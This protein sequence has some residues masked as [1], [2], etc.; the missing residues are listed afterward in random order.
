MPAQGNST[1]PNADVKSGS[2][3][4]ADIVQ[5]LIDYP[6]R[7]RL[8]ILAPILRGSRGAHQRELEDLRKAGFARLRIDGEIYELRPGLTLNPNQRHDIDV[9][10]DRIVIKEGR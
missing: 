4:A 2:Q 8:I 6:E 9:V 10:I 3:T 7:T 1:V 5:A